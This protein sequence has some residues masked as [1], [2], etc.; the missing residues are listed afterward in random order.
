[1]SSAQSN[2]LTKHLNVWV[3][4]DSAWLDMIK[5]DKCKAELEITDYTDWDAYLAVDLASKN[6]I[7]CIAILL[8]KKINTDCLLIRLSMRKQPN[9]TR[10]V[11]TMGGFKTV[12]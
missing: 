2:F 11:N 3:N 4:A 6:D 5:W 9:I 12:T 8:K 1:M 10:I 7:A